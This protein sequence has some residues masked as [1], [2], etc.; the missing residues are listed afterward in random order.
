MDSS[1][2]RTSSLMDL[3][4]CCSSKDLLLR[5]ESDIL[6]IVI[7]AFDPTL[8]NGREGSGFNRRSS[9]R[10]WPERAKGTKG[11]QQNL[12]GH[13][14]TLCVRIKEAMRTH[15]GLERHAYL[16]ERTPMQLRVP[17]GLEGKERVK[18][19]MLSIDTSASIVAVPYRAENRS[20]HGL[21]STQSKIKNGLV[22]LADKLDDNSFFT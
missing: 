21:N 1:K 14:W 11:S 7:S 4:K 17:N 19:V 12:E 5:N 10:K 3:E 6:N 22:P 20:Y 13:C 16:A 2:D 9:K 18:P 15:P 8:D